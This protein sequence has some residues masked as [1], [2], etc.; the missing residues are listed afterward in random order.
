MSYTGVILLHSSKVVGSVDK[1][2]HSSDTG[3]NCP[4]GEG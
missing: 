2:N 4:V 1:G 3:C